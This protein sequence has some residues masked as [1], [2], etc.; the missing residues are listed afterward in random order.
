M[1]S[2]SELSADQLRRLAGV[3]D[4]E[5]AHL[6]TADLLEEMLIRVE[7][8]LDVDT[9]TVLLLDRPGAQLIALAAHGLEEE[10]HQGV[11]LPVGRGFAGRIAA[12]RQPLAL[13]DVG[14]ENVVNPILWK[15]GI[16]SMLGVPMIA[17]GSLVG[18]MHVGTLRPRRFSEDETSVL[19]HAANRIATALIVQQA[20]AERSAART[21]QQSLLPT[22]LPDVDGLELATR[23]VAAAEDFGVGG[24]WYDA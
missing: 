11:R 22:R 3:I 19:Q 8:L 9:V 15:K 7:E 13:D 18:V 4:P 24:D 10:V 6:E 1:T 20:F 23:F 12:T 14:P 5:L 17:G 16:R 21:L 2:G